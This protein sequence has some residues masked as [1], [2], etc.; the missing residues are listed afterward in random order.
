MK[1]QVCRVHPPYFTIALVV[2]E[3]QE[4]GRFLDTHALLEV[5]EE[6]P[7]ADAS[8]FRRSGRSTGEREEQVA[9]S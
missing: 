9:L 3:C 7:L 8:F 1:T 2:L 5:R 6:L 4:P